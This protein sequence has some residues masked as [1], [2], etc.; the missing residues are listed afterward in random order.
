M[1]AINC[2]DMVGGSTDA[3][4][5]D[6]AEDFGAAFTVQPPNLQRI[7]DS[8]ESVQRPFYRGPGVGHRFLI[9]ERVVAARPQRAC[10]IGA[11]HLFFFP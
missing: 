3:P 1:T 6:H 5:V 2:D 8:A 7:F 10:F 4:M 9:W 11:N